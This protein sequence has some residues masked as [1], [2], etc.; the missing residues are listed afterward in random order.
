MCND[1]RCECLPSDNYI[2]GTE[3]TCNWYYI[4][5][6]KIHDMYAYV[7]MGICGDTL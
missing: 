6:S 3:G 1:R 4:R 2:E 5:G 7:H